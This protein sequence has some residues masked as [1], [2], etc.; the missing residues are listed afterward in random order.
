MSERYLWEVPVPPEV[1]ELAAAQPLLPDPEAED[2]DG[3]RAE[4]ASAARAAIVA[5]IG[6]IIASTLTDKQRRIVELHFFEG[7]SQA[8]V[9]A[10][11]GISQQ[12]VSRQLFGVLRNGRRV[13]GAVRRLRRACEAA[14][15]DPGQWV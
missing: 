12:V 6:V 7:R 2:V 9:A 1:F 3:L 15:L 10:Q 8:D 14:G 5:E 4:R 11:L 13:G